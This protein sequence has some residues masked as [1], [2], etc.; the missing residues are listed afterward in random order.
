MSE[1]NGVETNP[2]ERIVI[3]YCCGWCG[4]PT[5][6][7]GYALPDIPKEYLSFWNGA[8]SVNG[9]CCEAEIR[10]QEEHEHEMMKELYRDV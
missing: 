2:V 6:E 4:A 10:N 8:V 5:N 9:I 3:R 1:T 7:R